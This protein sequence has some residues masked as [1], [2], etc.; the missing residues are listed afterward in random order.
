MSVFA[1]D[2][3]RR[4][5]EQNPISIILIFVVTVFHFWTQLNTEMFQ[6]FALYT[7]YI[8]EREEWWRLFTVWLVHGDLLHYLFN[9]FFGILIF[10]A[11]LERIIGSRRFAVIFFG[12]GILASLA[13]VGWDWYLVEM[14]DMRPTVGISGAIFGVLGAFLYLT[15]RHPDWFAPSDISSIR[16]LIILNVVFTFLYPNISIPGHIGGLMAGFLVAMALPYP[17]G[18]GGGRRRRGFE[19]PYGEGYIDPAEDDVIDADI[20][21]EDEDDDDPF[22]RYDR[23]FK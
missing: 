4:A 9:T 16:G 10:S 5:Y 11:A 7:P 19:D 2:P 17:G 13:I 22:G 21:I 12:S 23:Y 18:P 15:M 3:Y 1:R 6:R 14:G 20:E 8:V